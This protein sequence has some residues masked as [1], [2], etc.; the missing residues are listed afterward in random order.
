MDQR[1]DH[2]LVLTKMSAARAAATR[3]NFAVTDDF[4]AE[5]DGLTPGI[6]WRLLVSF[7][8]HETA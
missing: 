2:I 1:L 7:L 8:P 4:K 3:I 6:K 5:H